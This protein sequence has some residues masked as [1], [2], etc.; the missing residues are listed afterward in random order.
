MGGNFFSHK[1]AKICVEK[2]QIGKIIGAGVKCCAYD[3]S[4]FL[5]QNFNIVRHECV[6]RDNFPRN[7]C[8]HKG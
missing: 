5:G 6:M 2:D 4:I 1:M 8:C 3:E 7:H